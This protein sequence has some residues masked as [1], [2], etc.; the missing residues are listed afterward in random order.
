MR[1]LNRNK[2]VFYYALYEGKEP[3]IDDY[4]NVTGE[5]EVKYSR[6]KKFRANISAANGKADVEQFGA[7][8]DYDKIIVGD[9]IFPQIDEYTIMWIDTVP[10]IDNEGKTETP[11][12]Y[13]VKKIARS[14]NSVSIAVSKVEVSR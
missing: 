3:V 14:L 2:T 8:V 4:G 10:V 11:H 9:N 5:Y 6:P 12:D 1:T 13:I 7:N